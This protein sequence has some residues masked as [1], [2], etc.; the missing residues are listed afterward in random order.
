M[1]HGT[2]PNHNKIS[3]RAN[4]KKDIRNIIKIVKGRHRTTKYIQTTIKKKIL[5]LIYSYQVINNRRFTVSQV[6]LIISMTIE[7]KNYSK[8]KIVKS[9][10]IGKHDI[11]NH[12]KDFQ[13][14][15]KINLSA[16]EK[17]YFEKLEKFEEENGIN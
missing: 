14:N 15:Y 3:L 5:E 7:V 12:I 6:N 13:P 11:W 9:I 2:H 17:T 4:Y 10:Y 8:S 16:E 1:E